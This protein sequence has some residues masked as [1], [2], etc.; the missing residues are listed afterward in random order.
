MTGGDTHSLGSKQKKW[1]VTSFQVTV[2]GDEDDETPTDDTTVFSPD[3]ANLA[4]GTLRL[5]AERLDSGD[6]RVY[7]MVVRGTD[8]SGN[9]GY[10][11]TTVMVPHDSSNGSKAAVS[12]QAEDAQTYCEANGGAPPAGYQVIGDGPVMGPKRKR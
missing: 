7:L 1:L 9:T 6:G 2:Y 4:I 3:A 8:N 5:R 11:C 12:V 10:T